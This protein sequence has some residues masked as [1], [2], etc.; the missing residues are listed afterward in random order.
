MLLL[1]KFLLKLKERMG[2]PEAFRTKLSLVSGKW[3]GVTDL[4]DSNI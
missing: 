2:G 1:D 4:D 3:V